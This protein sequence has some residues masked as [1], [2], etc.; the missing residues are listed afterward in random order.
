MNF[1]I[2]AVFVLASLGGAVMM[3]V[4]RHPMH[5]ALGLITTMIS[6]G[7]I[8]AML[9]VHV[10]AV[11]QILIYVS[12]VMVFVVYV[13]MLLDTRDPSFSHRYSTMLV[14]GAVAGLLLLAILTSALMGSPFAEAPA[15]F[16]KVK[17]VAFGVKEFSISFL[18]DYWLHFE[19][20]S[21]LLLAAVVA[22]VAVIKGEGERRD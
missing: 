1:A 13:I 18:K 10:I 19:L 12:A 21:V 2:M 4:M 6:L 16:A 8:Y 5:V 20:T 9:D 17:D 11:F 14:P 15:S 22:A 3:L 7:G